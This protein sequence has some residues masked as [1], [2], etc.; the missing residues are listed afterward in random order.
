MRPT[1]QLPAAEPRRARQQPRPSGWEYVHVAVDDYR[2][3]AYVEVLADE[4]AA[5]AIG[6][7]EPSS[8]ILRPLR[9]I[10]SSAC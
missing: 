3:L 2:R 8:R 7:L 5:T 4:K 9:G 6:F 10:R 1:A